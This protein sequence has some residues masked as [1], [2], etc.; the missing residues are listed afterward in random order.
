MGKYGT[1]KPEYKHLSRSQIEG[2]AQQ[3][4]TNHNALS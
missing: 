3:L 1:E 2:E 4:G